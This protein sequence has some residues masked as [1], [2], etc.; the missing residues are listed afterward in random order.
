MVGEWSPSPQRL[1]I[2][3]D[4]IDL[5]EAEPNDPAAGG[6]HLAAHP[7]VTHVAAVQCETTTGIIN[8]IVEKQILTPTARDEVQ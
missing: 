6:S 2:A 8:L 7:E 5:W 3:V 4:S 1:G